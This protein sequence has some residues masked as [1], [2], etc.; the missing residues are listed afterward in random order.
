MRISKIKDDGARVA[1]AEARAAATDSLGRSSTAEATR[2]L[3]AANK[4]KRDY[5]AAHGGVVPT[6]AAA[7]AWVKEEKAR[8]RELE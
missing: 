6:F 8:G 1:A 2:K 4:M 3:E 7:R 5:A